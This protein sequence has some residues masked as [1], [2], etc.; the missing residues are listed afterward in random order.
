M[1]LITINSRL[2]ASIQAEKMV[3]V[4]FIN[5]F[6]ITFVAIYKLCQLLSVNS[7]KFSE[8]C[9]SCLFRTL[10]QG[11]HLVENWLLITGFDRLI[12]FS[13]A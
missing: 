5:A 8:V 3:L 1:D 12:R 11:N 6:E 7:L 9:N 2:F 10:F 13:N 4:L